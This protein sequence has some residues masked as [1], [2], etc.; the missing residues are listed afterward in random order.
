MEH[1]NYS[2]TVEDL[3]INSS[4]PWRDQFR[5]KESAL[6][7]RWKIGGLFVDTD[8]E[9]INCYW[10]QFEPVPLPSH[11]ILAFIFFAI[12]AVGSLSNALVI[13]IMT[14]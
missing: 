12:F 14:T 5:K 10:L 11:I 2:E 1:Q 4:C 3:S 8:L 13:Y 9:D 6:I 7:E